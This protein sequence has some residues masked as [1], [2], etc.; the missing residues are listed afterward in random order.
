MSSNA[1][2][3]A[4]SPAV[5]TIGDSVVHLW[6]C[7]DPIHSSIYCMQVHSCVADDGGSAKVTVV[8]S[9]GCPT[10]E[11]LLSSITYPTPLR[12]FARSRVFKFADKSDI[13]FAC[14][15][16]L[17][18]KQDAGNGTCAGVACTKM[19][20]ANGQNFVQF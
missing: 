2:T 13:N 9:N 8:D 1:S 18:M 11:E 19:G 6:T 7:G 12:A 15:I 10:D 4:S 14:Q 17:M 16:R 5:V 3:A 20:G